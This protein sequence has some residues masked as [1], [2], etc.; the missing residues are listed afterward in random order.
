MYTTA[1][2]LLVASFLCAVFS[3]GALL[4]QLATQRNN[5]LA[6]AERAHLALTILMSVA[7][8]VLLYAFTTFDFSLEYVA[9][10][11][12]LTLPLFY[13]LTALWAGQAGSLLFWG[14]SVAVCGLIFMLC[15]P[16]RNL[17]DETKLW[18]W[19]FFL[20]IM[21]F[22]L[23]LITAWSNP[24]VTL[25]VPPRDGMG[26]N[27]LLQN[28]GMIFHPPLLFLG[29][30]GFVV[31]GCLALAQTLSGRLT[32]NNTGECTEQPWAETS[33]AFILVAWLLLTAGIVLGAWWAYMELGWG[34]YW[35]WDPVENASLIP[36]L[37]ASAYLHTGIVESY[38][39]KLRRANVFLMA[40][41]TISAFFA[42]YLVR[43]GVIQSLHA[44]PDGGV[45]K[46]LLLFVLASLFLAIVIPACSKERSQEIGGVN[47][48]EGLLSFVAWFLLALAIII[49]IATIWPVIIA[50]V[51]GISDILPKA[52]Q[53]ALPQKPMG[54]EPAFYNR[55]C[56]P[57]FACLAALLVICP[58]RQWKN[59]WS[60]PKALVGALAVTLFVVAISWTMGITHPVALLASGAS[61]GALGGI[62]LLF[63]LK[64]SLLNIRQTLAAHGVHIGLLLTVAGVAFSGPYQS[65][66]SLVLHKEKSRA[67]TLSSFVN[68][69]SYLPLAGE[70]TVVLNELY[71]GKSLHQANGV[72]HYQFLK[73]DV[74]VFRNNSFVGK[75]EPQVRVYSSSPNQPF[76]EVSTVFSLGNELY[77]TLSHIDEQGNAHLQI[78]VNPLVNWLW[79]GGIVMCLFPFLGLAPRRRKGVATAQE[80]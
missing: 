78:N 11:S 30:G 36:W 75:L 8:L 69:K 41:T 10:Y 47:T 16:Y 50:G 9:Q 38:R 18:Y 39:G 25:P 72:P 65:S 74:S 33:R 4:T 56:L 64:P 68:A 63:A 61:F 32:P 20:A 21:G 46:P 17:S 43:S 42:T 80:V 35:A 60:N 22:F 73:A 55:T 31:P 79:L 27:P 34:G 6:W 57:L 71:E 70:Y 28:P 24:F 12:D 5:L 7:V 23:L 3:T 29:Y 15:P 1:H 54:L 53:A 44:Y 76:R 26:L 49:L 58:F 48:K 77:A 59:G 51:I 52:W 14:W 2:L 67:A 37:V 13:R 40:L 19:V 62:I 66:Y 45:G